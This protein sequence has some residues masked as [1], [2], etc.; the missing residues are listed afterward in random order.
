MT[1]RKLPAHIRVGPPGNVI[2]FRIVPP[3]SRHRVEGVRSGQIPNEYL[4]A[5]RQVFVV[6]NLVSL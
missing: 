3:L 1:N 5:G 2:S 6:C 4:P